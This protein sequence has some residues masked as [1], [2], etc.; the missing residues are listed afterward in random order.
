MRLGKIVGVCE[1]ALPAVQFGRLH[2]WNSL[3]IKTILS[4]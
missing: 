2:M 4:K 3:Q 1:A